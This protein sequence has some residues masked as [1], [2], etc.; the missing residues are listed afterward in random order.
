M[1]SKDSI[2]YVPAIMLAISAGYNTEDTVFLQSCA[3]QL[4]WYVLRQEPL[5]ANV[6]GKPAE[7]FLQAAIWPVSLI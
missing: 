7:R 1:P 4:E 3:A 2:Y 5:R 6:Q